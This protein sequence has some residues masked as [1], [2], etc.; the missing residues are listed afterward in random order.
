METSTK[1][2]SGQIQ[3]DSL[4]VNCLHG[5]INICSVQIEYEGMQRYRDPSGM[6]RTT[7]YNR[8]DKIAPSGD[9]AFYIDSLMPNTQ[10]TFNITAAFMDGSWGPPF[11]IHVE[12]TNAGQTLLSDCIFFSLFHLSFLTHSFALLTSQ[13][14]PG[15]I[16]FDRCMLFAR[17]CVLPISVASVFVSSYEHSLLDRSARVLNYALYPCLILSLHP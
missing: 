16:P 10:Y 14:P 9:R 12:T 3:G 13:G 11:S 7:M 8:T 6:E 5:Y 2:R 4:D 17:P 1:T 15:L